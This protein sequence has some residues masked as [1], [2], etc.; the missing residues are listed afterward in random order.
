[1]DPRSVVGDNVGTKRNRRWRLSLGRVLLPGGLFLI[2]F[3][4]ALTLSDGAVAS[5]RMVLSKAAETWSFRL[6]H[7][8]L[9]G[10]R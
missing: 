6:D 5:D 3:L 9:A 10:E 2:A 1:M 8:A 7:G 4:R